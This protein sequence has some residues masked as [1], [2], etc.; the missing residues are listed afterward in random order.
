MCMSMRT[1]H[2]H[3]T[4]PAMVVDCPNQ[5][6]QNIAAEI[7]ARYRRRLDRPK[8]MLSPLAILIFLHF[9]Y[10]NRS[11]QVVQLHPKKK[12]MQKKITINEY[13]I[14]IILMR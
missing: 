7:G 5:I 3:D 2:F 10:R 8:M 12:I 9:Q 11:E 1:W 13:Q 14:Y 4:R 6:Q